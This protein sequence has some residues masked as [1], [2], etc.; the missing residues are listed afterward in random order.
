MGRTITNEDQ[1]IFQEKLKKPPVTSNFCVS[2][3]EENQPQGLTPSA[4]GGAEGRLK[5]GGPLC[6]PCALHLGFT[7]TK[8]GFLVVSYMFHVV[9]HGFEF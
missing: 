1:N 6:L 2:F 4:F 8:S 5:M 9:F 3:L 7:T